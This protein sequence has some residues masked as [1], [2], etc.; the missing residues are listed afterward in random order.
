MKLSKQLKKII[1]DD[2][3]RSMPTLNEEEVLARLEPHLERKVPFFKQKK[4][5]WILR[6]GYSL[7]LMLLSFGICFGVCK[8][9]ESN[10]LKTN[11]FFCEAKSAFENEFLEEG[12]YNPVIQSQVD[13]KLVYAVS[14]NESTQSYDVLVYSKYR[15]STILNVEIN[16]TMYFDVQGVLR[17][18]TDSLEEIELTFYRNDILYFTTT[19]KK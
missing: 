19:Y 1:Q 14:L 8:L 12:F 10:A 2:I 17:H 3:K 6:I 7:A 9:T 13:T 18:S 11:Q 16:E 15:E 4:G 5:L